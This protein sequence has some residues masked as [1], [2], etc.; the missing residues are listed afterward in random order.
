M[1]ILDRSRFSNQIYI[2]IAC[3]LCGILISGGLLIPYLNVV[4]LALAVVFILLLDREDGLCFL[5]F[6]V[7]FAPI[8]KL[9]LGSFTLY[10]GLIIIMLLKLI[11]ANSGMVARKY[12]V[13][14]ILLT[15]YV[16]LIGQ[17]NNLKDTLSF[18]AYLLLAGLI[19]DVEQRSYNLH[20]IVN[21]TAFGIIFSSIISLNRESLPR[22]AAF[23]KDAT[24][25]LAPG[26]Y[27]YRFSGLESNPNYYT[28]MISI[29]LAVFVVLFIQSRTTL[30]DYVLMVVLC[31]F[32]LMSLS[33]SFLVSLIIIGISFFAT[34]AVSFNRKVLGLLLFAIIGAFVF[35]NLD[36]ETI[37]T[38]LFRIES[39]DGYG[40]TSDVTTGRSTLWIQYIQYILDNFKVLLLGT[41]IGAGNLSV[42][43]SHNYYIDIIYH[44]GI[45]GGFIYTAFL[46]SVFSVRNYCLKKP[47]F[48]RYIPFVVFIARGFARNLIMSEQ[49]I[50]MLIL[51]ALSISDGLTWDEHNSE[52]YLCNR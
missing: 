30:I 46:H 18:L 42:G 41:G 31:V 35:L 14:F 9:N 10:S 38:W 36:Q 24:V 11:F 23:L 47:E 37:N 28:M 44:L 43:A 49:L 33:N 32:G 21:Y 5:G 40:N 2:L 48:Y 27:Y 26:E 4:A 52:E 34:Q 20:K 25:R 17:G 16:L 3:I 6:L 22:L 19:F 7:F 29:C 12:G 8:F 50:F 51:C 13:P 39:I 1:Q 45:I 15:F